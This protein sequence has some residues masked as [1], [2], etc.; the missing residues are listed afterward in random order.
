[1]T[2]GHTYVRGLLAAHA[3]GALEDPERATVHDHVEGCE[4]CRHELKELR[5][6][7]TSTLGPHAEPPEAG[8][9]RVSGALRQRPAHEGGDDGG[10]PAAEGGAASTG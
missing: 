8:W 4:A 10:A 9:S 5:E 2:T 3:L 7:A 6:T 1:M